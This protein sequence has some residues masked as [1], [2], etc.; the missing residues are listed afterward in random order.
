MW[1]VMFCNLYKA[2]C[3]LR[4]NMDFVRRVQKQKLWQRFLSPA[5]VA[6]RRRLWEKRRKAGWCVEE[7]DGDDAPERPVHV[8]VDRG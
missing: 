5:S 3:V 7:I 2:I 6:R 4:H 1:N 8:H